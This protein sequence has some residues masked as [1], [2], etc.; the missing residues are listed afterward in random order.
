VK[1]DQQY[2]LRSL[3][4]SRLSILGLVHC[5]SFQDLMANC[6]AIFIINGIFIYNQWIS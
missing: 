6:D 5:K 3:L 2:L 4:F 1:L